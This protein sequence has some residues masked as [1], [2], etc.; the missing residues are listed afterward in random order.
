MNGPYQSAYASP[1][2]HSWYHFSTGN[3][4]ADLGLWIGGESTI[5]AIAGQGGALSQQGS[6]GE[7]FGIGRFLDP[8]FNML[9]TGQAYGHGAMSG[10]SISQYFKNGRLNLF[11]ISADAHRGTG[12]FK[13]AA[14]TTGSERLASVIG[15]KAATRVG[16]GALLKLGV[17]SAFTAMNFGLG[18]SLGRGIGEIIAN[19]ETSHPRYDLTLESGGFFAD[20]R[21]SFTQRQRAIQTIHNSQ[22]TTRAALGG[23]A[24]FVHI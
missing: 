13:S 16:V 8:K 24:S 9:R 19:Y 6:I 21:A 12:L 5:S 3:I 17:R 1:Q 23:E 22:L 4:L 14:G 15:R 2:D 10:Q 18:L 7:H 20:T 11:K